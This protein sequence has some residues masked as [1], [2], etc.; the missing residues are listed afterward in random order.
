M[1]EVVDI[2]VGGEGQEVQLPLHRNG[3]EHNY[4]VMRLTNG[5]WAIGRYGTEDVNYVVPACHM[6]EDRMMVNDDTIPHAFRAC[7]QHIID[8]TAAPLPRAQAHDQEQQN[9]ELED[10]YAYAYARA[11]AGFIA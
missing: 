10:A 7:V 6:F 4:L 3:K 5:R 9:M 11:H 8:D 1:Y 2:V